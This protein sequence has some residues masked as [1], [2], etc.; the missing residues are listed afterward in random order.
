MA[1]EFFQNLYTR[2]ENI[3]PDIIIDMLEQCVNEEMNANLYAPFSEKEITDALFQIGPLKAPGPDGFPAHF[4]QGNWGLLR[5]DV[6]RAVQRFFLDGIMPDEVNDT[7]IVL[8]PKKVDP[9]ELKDFRPISLCNVI[10]KTG[11]AAR[12]NFYAYKLDM[13]KAYD[14]VDWR[15]LEGV[16][17]KLGF[18]SQ[19]IQWVMAS[20]TTCSP[21]VQTVLKG[22]L[23][24][25]TV[26]FEEKYL[27]LLVPDGRMS[28]GKFKPTKRKFSKNASDWAEKYISSRAKEILIKSVLQSIS[29][30]AMGV[31]EFPMGLVDDLHKIIRDFWWGDED[32]RRK[33]H[34]LAWDKITRPKTQG[35]VGFRDLRVLNQALLARQAWRLIQF[36]D[37]LCARLLKA[38]YYPFGDLLDTAFI[39]NQSQTWQGI[40]Y[41][42]DLLKQGIIWRIGSGSKV[43]I[44][45]D[46]WLPRPGTMKVEGRRN[47]SRRRW[48]SELINPITRAWDDVAIRSCY[49][50]TDSDAIL[51]IKLPARASGD[52]VAWSA[53]SNGIFSVRSAYRIGVNPMIQRL[54]Q[55][56]SS[57]EPSGDR[58]IWKMA[59]EDSHHAL[60]RCTLARALRDETR[61]L[62]RLPPEEDFEYNGK[63]WIL[64][65]LRSIPKSDRPKRPVILRT[66]IVLK[67]RWL[68][69]SG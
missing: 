56:Q 5:D 13:A 36:P 43:G 2:E 30:Y 3:N 35:G 32:D 9:E 64:Q 37:S 15:F 34:W 24:Y 14:R 62:W 55:G 20:V 48:V 53:E 54:S 22:I 31:F 16:L 7:A 17:A 42:L 52:F 58:S 40:V 39:Q 69:P 26:C 6:A 63:E 4:L 46:N 59:V 38:R 10:F 45:R 1:T 19:L 44:F 18:R 29:T 66:I 21:E 51:S 61:K 57:S 50:P 28:K 49:S 25:E 68:S 47:N 27:G 11:S 12:R 41:G 8:I 23:K 33:M 67:I 65:L 60:I